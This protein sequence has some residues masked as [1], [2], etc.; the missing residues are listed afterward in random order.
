MGKRAE[1]PW[2]VSMNLVEG[3]PLGVIYGTAYARNAQGEKII[4]QDGFPLVSKD[5]Q[6]LGN[7]NPKWNLG[8]NSWL[9]FRA[10]T[11]AF[12]WDWRYGGE[13]W[14][15]TSNVLNYLGRSEL[16]ANE[17]STRNY[18]FEGVTEMGQ[19]NAR[20]VDFANP[21][22][23]LEAN[24]WVRYGK[25]GVG[26]DAIQKASFLRLSEVKLTYTFYTNFLQKIRLRTANISLIARNLLLFTPYRGTDPATSLF[27]YGIANGLDLFN[28]PNTRSFGATMN[29]EF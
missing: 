16:T 21:A 6:L 15:G 27:G 25:A 13:R 18:I 24:R 26:E 7:P 28:A 14:N 8:I 1:F 20:P 3:E 23:G 12:L 2:Q 11:L 19:P 22:N 17:R 29:L 4:G 5:L 10:W 9:S